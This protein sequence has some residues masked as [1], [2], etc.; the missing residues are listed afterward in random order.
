[1]IGEVDQAAEWKKQALAATV[2]AD[3]LQTENETLQQKNDDLQAELAAL[4]LWHGRA[5]RI[6]REAV[7]NMEHLISESPPL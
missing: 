6:L 4:E 2:R 1:M 7:R 3:R 5:H